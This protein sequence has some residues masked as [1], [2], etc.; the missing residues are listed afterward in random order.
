VTQKRVGQ[1]L[2]RRRHALI[3]LHD[4]GLVNDPN[5][6]LPH[7]KIDGT[8]DHGWLLL[9]EGSVSAEHIPR[10]VERKLPR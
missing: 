5:L 1:A 9:F 6:T 3:A 10:F 4:A 7:M 8:I 2:A